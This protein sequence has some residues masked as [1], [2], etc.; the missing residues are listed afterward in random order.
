V[1]Q[2]SLK[3]GPVVSIAGTRVPVHRALQ[4]ILC[5]ECGQ[6]IEEGELFT[7]WPLPG[8]AHLYAMPKGECCSPFDFASEQLEKSPLLRALLAEKPPAKRPRRELGE[9][10]RQAFQS[11]LGPVLTRLKKR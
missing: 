4:Q 7:R 6:P 8:A 5:A 10:T 9:E 3:L 1:K 11:R 2:H